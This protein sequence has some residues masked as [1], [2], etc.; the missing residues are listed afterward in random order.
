[1]G[2]KSREKRERNHTTIAQHERK[3][4]NLHPPISKIENLTKTSW[5]DNRLPEFLWIG[6]IIH[7]NERLV[8]LD[9]IR[10]ISKYFYDRNEELRPEELSF[11][12]IAAMPDEQIESFYNFLFKELFLA[13][14]L[15]PLLIFNSLPKKDLLEKHISLNDEKIEIELAKLYSSVANMIDH[16]SQLATD[17]RWARIYYLMIKG[18]LHMGSEAENIFYYPQQGDM[19]RVRPTIRACENAM[20]LMGKQNVWVEKFWT[21]ALH[22]S[23]CWDLNV[24]EEEESDLTPLMMPNLNEVEN[25][26]IEHFYESRSTSAIDAKHEA[27]F[28][29]TLYC[30]DILKELT[31]SGIQN[32][33]TGRLGL[34]TIAE[35]YITLAYL[36]KKNDEQLWLSYRSYGSGQ[37]KLAFL[38]IDE[39]EK[40]PQFVSLDTLEALANEDQWQE[41]SNINLGHWENSNLRA[42]SETARVKDVY[43]SY[44]DWTSGFAHGQWSSLRSMEFTICGNPLHRLHRIP[45]ENKKLPTTVG[46]AADL[47]NKIIE[48]LFELYPNEKVP[49]LNMT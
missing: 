27:A 5:K 46:D 1:M 8:G 25:T 2:R 42:M 6:L 47:C 48:I 28:A 12:S 36:V 9:Y 40:Q 29:F 20:S 7:L 35:C 34:R 10:Q 38:K 26:I 31:D 21:E 14:E 24:K 19:R 45:N 4:K 11:T 49:L 37:A 44:Y 3:G 17:C 41:F 18:K 13:E 32:G 16:Q 30:L 33:I 22:N 39:L 43:N 23:P 15:K